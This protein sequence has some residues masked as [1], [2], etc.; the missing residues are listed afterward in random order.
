MAS[1][2]EEYRVVFVGGVH[3]VGKTTFCRNLAKEL[4]G[5]HVSASSLIGDPA[6]VGRVVQ[7]VEE[8]QQLLVERLRSYECPSALLLLD[9]HFALSTNDGLVQRVPIWT[10]RE[11]GPAALVLLT[12]PTETLH[13]RLLAR[14]RD[15]P[16]PGEIDALQREESA[17]AELV[18][19]SL[20][21][22]LKTIAE[23]DDL[24]RREAVSFLLQLPVNPNTE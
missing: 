3:G 17:T 16:T 7:S 20:G 1:P 19:S 11:I 18:A 13:A 22:P 4:G 2:R 9:G 10:F 14:D 24:Q 15:A 12:A 6:R 8:N 5:T 21:I 23:Q